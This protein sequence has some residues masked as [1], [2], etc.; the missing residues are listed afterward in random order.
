MANSLTFGRKAVIIAVIATA[1]IMFVTSFV[2]RMNN[3]N[4]FVKAQMGG[5]A[6]EAD[7]DHDGDGVQDHGDGSAITDNPD[8]K[9]SMGGAMGGASN[10]AMARVREFMDRVDKD[11]NDVEALVGLGNSFLMMRAWDRAIEPLVKAQSIAPEDINVYKAVGIAYFNTEQFEKA[12]KSYE[13]ILKIDGN[14]TLALFNLGVI[15]KHYF[16]NEDVAKTYFEKVLVIEK[17]DAEMIK[18]AREEL[19]K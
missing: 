11:P 8:K 1:V 9:T 15:N 6:Q 19:G 17:D 4:L 13:S 7:H 18:L 14:D 5:A 16:K 3:P 12:A 10:G 2:Y